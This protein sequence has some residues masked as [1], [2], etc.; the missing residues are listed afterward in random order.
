MPKL[1]KKFD[2]CISLEVAEHLSQAKAKHF[3]DFLCTASDIV[4]FIAAIKYQG[5]TKHTN[6]QWQSYWI[7]QFKSHAFDC[8]DMIRPHLW[9]HTLVEWYYNQ[10]IF[11]FVGPNNSVLSLN[12]LKDSEKPIFDVVHPLND[13]EK[14]ISYRQ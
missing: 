8:V 5:G 9:N 14:A 4:L 6:E 2:L 7:D 11:L 1:N 10:N 12:A 3:I 13:E